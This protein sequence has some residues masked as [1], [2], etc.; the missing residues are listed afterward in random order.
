MSKSETIMIDEVKYV[1]ADSVSNCSKAHVVDSVEGSENHGI[2]IVVLERGF[3]YVGRVVTD[4]NWCYITDA[5]NIRTW[6][7]TKGLSELVN[8][9]LSN[10]KLDKAGTVRANIMSVI[11]LISCEESTWQT[12]L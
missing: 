9:P 12:E 4:G 11:H 7:T 10:T 6:G 2:C 8:G 5:S 1:R 3:V